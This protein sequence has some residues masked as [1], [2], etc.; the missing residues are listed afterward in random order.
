[1]SERAAS[2]PLVTANQITSVRLLLMPLVCYLAYE[3]R[4]WPALAMGIVIGSTDFVDGYLARKH[5][6]TVLGGLM[7]PIADKIF[8]AFAYLPLADMGIIPAWAVAVMFVREFVVTAL[9]SAYELRDLRMKTSYLAKV[10]TWTQMQGLGTA[11]L[12]ML[13][14]DE[15][16]ILLGIVIAALAAPVVAL[17][18]FWWFKRRLWKGALV[19]G[20]LCTPLVILFVEDDLAL[21]I[22]VIIYVIVGIT[23]VSG[24]DYLLVGLRKLRGHGDFGRAD[25]VRLLGA[26]VLPGLIF[27]ALVETPVSGWPLVFILAVELAVGGLDNLLA[28]HRASAGAL[29]WGARVLGTSALLAATLLLSREG[30]A[31]VVD[32]LVGAAVVVSVLGVAREFWRGRAYYLD[33]KLRGEASAA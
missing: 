27:A 11:V 14:A 15:R 29:A 3:M 4:W 9:R 31:D 28:H 16:Q 2:R 20:L 7:D 21:T 22:D 26:L 30:H 12:F 10:K 19:M 5:G 23:W 32:W 17:G 13:L 24:A 8:I 1:M 33:S 25:T 6:P 18:L